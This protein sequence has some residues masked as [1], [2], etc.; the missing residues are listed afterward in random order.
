MVAAAPGVLVPAPGAFARVR[1]GGAFLRSR[2]LGSGQVLLDLREKDGLA[3]SKAAAPRA[4]VDL[5]LRKLGESLEPFDGPVLLLEPPIVELILE[6]PK[7]YVQ[8]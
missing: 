1:S 4:D 5:V 2:G 3:L 6:L 7:P 8:Y